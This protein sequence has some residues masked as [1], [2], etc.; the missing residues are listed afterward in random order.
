MPREV[1]EEPRRLDVRKEFT[2]CVRGLGGADLDTTLPAVRGHEN[3][4]FFFEE[5]NVVV[6]LKCLEKNH[7]AA[8]E[9]NARLSRIYS[10]GRLLKPTGVL[11]IKARPTTAPRM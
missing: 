9:F 7:F 11:R 10:E 1:N 8:D 2:A 4:D 3:A 5:F 6:E